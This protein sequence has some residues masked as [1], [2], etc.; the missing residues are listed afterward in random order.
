VEKNEKN[1][2]ANE[3]LL[4]AH[5]YEERTP[6]KETK[7]LRGRGAR[8]LLT[9][10]VLFPVQ[11][12]ARGDKKIESIPCSQQKFPR[13]PSQGELRKED[14]Y[15]KGERE[16][17]SFHS[18]EEEWGSRGRQGQR[19]RREGRNRA[20]ARGAGPVMGTNLGGWVNRRAA[21][22]QRK[23]KGQGNT[24]SA[25]GTGGEFNCQ[26]ACTHDKLRPF[27]KGERTQ[28][29][30]DAGEF[31]RLEDWLAPRREAERMKKDVKSDECQGALGNQDGAFHLN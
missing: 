22:V 29:E 14:S 3:T 4:V 25:P 6:D 16:Q 19:E 11:R 24:K 27:E 2:P 15:M 9:T 17:T 20:R 1:E 31:P 5:K 8:V 10:T 26:R 12:W 18:R 21:H 30:E 13:Q 28:T 7:W 23:G